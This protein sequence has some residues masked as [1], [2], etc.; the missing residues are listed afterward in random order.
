MANT[1]KWYR[2]IVLYCALIFGLASTVIMIWISVYG[3]IYADAT[4]GIM[5][6]GRM[7]YVSGLSTGV[8]VFVWCVVSI[9]FFI[10]AFSFTGQ[11]LSCLTCCCSC[12]GCISFMTI[13]IVLMA[14]TQLGSVSLM[15]NEEIRDIELLVCFILFSMII[16]INKLSDINTY[17]NI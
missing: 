16:I 5:R 13:S 6:Y 9:I 10:L 12:S 17:M 11:C 4:T 3:N 2:S 7:A 14:S 8:F 15:S 1:F